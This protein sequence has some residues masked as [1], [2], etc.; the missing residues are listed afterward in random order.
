M[1]FFFVLYGV[2]VVLFRFLGAWV[3]LSVVHGCVNT[4][5]R[6]VCV[7]GACFDLRFRGDI[8]QHYCY[9]CVAGCLIAVLKSGSAT[10]AVAVK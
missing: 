2:E 7:C 9:C 1:F 4:G 3:L 5:L 8:V 10:V 6:G